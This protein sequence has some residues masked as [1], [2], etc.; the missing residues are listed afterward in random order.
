MVDIKSYIT[1][2]YWMRENLGLS[3]NEL[4][5]Y[6]IIYG[7]SHDGESKFTGSAEWLAEWIGS[8]RKTVYRILKK[9]KE[10]KLIIGEDK[11]KKNNKFVDYRVNLRCDKMSQ[12]IGQNVPSP[13]DK[14]SHH[15]NSIHNIEDNK[16]EIYKE[17]KNT[18]NYFFNFDEYDIDNLQE[19]GKVIQEW[20]DYKR[21]RHNKY[22]DKGFSTF[23]KRLINLSNGE[24][25]KAQEIV[26]ISI[27]NNYQGI[28]PLKGRM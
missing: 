2:Q 8:S 28:F 11:I 13:T 7:F 19:F 3:G 24:Y 21:E 5:I 10:E 1:I 9:L 6:A 15:N 23:V 25:K 12:T 20:I 18:D 27:A 22:T 17:E 26:D 16:E 14:M 4:M